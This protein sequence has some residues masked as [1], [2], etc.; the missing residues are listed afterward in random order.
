[1]KVKNVLRLIRK[2]SLNVMPKRQPKV[3]RRDRLENRHRFVRAMFRPSYHESSSI[4]LMLLLHWFQE[5]D[6]IK[7]TK[8]TRITGN[9]KWKPDV[10]RSLIQWIKGLII[11]YWAVCNIKVWYVIDMVINTIIW[12]ELEL[13]MKQFK[14]VR[15]KLVDIN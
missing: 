3:T 7:T 10:C 8:A 14:I 5:D 4:F 12:G 1:M 6:K 15:W 9:E 13:T 11:S 2:S